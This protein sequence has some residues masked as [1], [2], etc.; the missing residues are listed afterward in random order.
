[1]QF[2]KAELFLPNEIIQ[3]GI[4]RLR[5]STFE[6]VGRREMGALIFGKHIQLPWFG[7]HEYLRTFPQAG[8]VMEPETSI[9]QFVDQV[10]EAR[11]LSLIHI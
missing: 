9:E 3:R 5:R 4:T 8:E 7:N 6:M 2:T 11:G 10:D 1:M